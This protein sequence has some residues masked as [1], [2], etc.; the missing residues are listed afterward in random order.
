MP[1]SGCLP[2]REIS[3]GAREKEI[4]G[5]GANK[6]DESHTR[7]SRSVRREKPRG[8]KKKAPSCVCA[9]TLPVRAF[10]LFFVVV[11]ME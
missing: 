2:E 5:G 3:R 4:P 1:S 8:E 6:N 9:R 10:F 7:R 11:V